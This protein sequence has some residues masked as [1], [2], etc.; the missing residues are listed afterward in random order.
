MDTIFAPIYDQ[1]WG[2]YINDTHRLYL[3]SFLDLLPEHAVVLDA[4][5]GTGKY[6]PLILQTGRAMRAVDQSAGM[7]AQASAKYL[8]V[9][10]RKLG[11]QEL[12][13]DRAFE[14]IV[15]IDAI[16]I[17]ISSRKRTRNHKCTI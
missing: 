13:Y 4:A 9:P 2:S 14:G 16:A 12:D 15:C 6:W 11:L 17:T 10:A 8:D 5:C 3:D 7:L 1:D